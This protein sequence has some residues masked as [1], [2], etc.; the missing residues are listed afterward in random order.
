MPL[1][2]PGTSHWRPVGFLGSSSRVLGGLWGGS[3]GVPWLI[4]LRFGPI[5]DQK[6][7]QKAVQKTSKMSGVFAQITVS[8]FSVFQCFSSVFASKMAPFL[9]VKWRKN[10]SRIEHSLKMFTKGAL[11]IPLGTFWLPWRPFRTLQG[12]PRTST[13]TQRDGEETAGVLFWRPPPP[14][15]KAPKPPSALLL[16]NKEK[17]TPEFRNFEVEIRNFGKQRPES[18]RNDDKEHQNW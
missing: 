7:C 13:L 1:R 10:R 3:W 11:G 5:F 9:A 8:A 17:G 18:W 4:L 12:S 14:R 2:P 15:G 6:W 16:R